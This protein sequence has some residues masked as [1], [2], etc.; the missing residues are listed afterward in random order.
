MRESADGKTRH[1]RDPVTLLEGGKPLTG[2][3]LPLDAKYPLGLSRFKLTKGDQLELVLEVTDYRGELSAKSASTEPIVLSV[4]DAEGVAS[5]VAE[6]DPKL[7][8]EF[9][10]LIQRQLDIGASK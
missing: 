10:A 5:A 9:D 4:T 2:A 7:E 1:A 3:Q 8:A 6:L